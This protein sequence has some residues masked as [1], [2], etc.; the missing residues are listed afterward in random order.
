MSRYEGGRIFDS[1]SS[2]E[3]RLEEVSRDCSAAHQ[4]AKNG[5]R[6]GGLAGKE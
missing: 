3:E 1:S 6:Y 5:D 2:L 4:A